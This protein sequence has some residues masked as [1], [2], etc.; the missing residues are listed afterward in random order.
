MKR[1]V[2]RKFWL[3]AVLMV[4]LAGCTERGNEVQNASLRM[5]VDSLWSNPQTAL[6]SL[7]QIEP[8]SLT[9]TERH[10]FI[11]T[12]AH[13]RLKL[14][15]VLEDE[16]AVNRAAAYCEEEQ[17]GRYAGEAYY[18]EGAYRN[19]TG[20]DAEAMQQ[21]K[22][23]ERAFDDEDVPAILLGM[24]YYKMGRI[25]ETEQLYAVAE[26]YYEQAVPYLDSAALPLYAACGWR[27]L[28][29]TTQDSVIRK[30]AFE[31][32]GFT[33]QPHLDF[34]I[35]CTDEEA[36]WARLS[37]NRKRQI[38]RA[39]QHGVHIEE[40]QNE[41]EIEA[42]YKILE[43]LYRTKVKTPLFPLSFFLTFY[44]QRLGKYLLVKHEGQIIGGIM[45]PVWNG[46][47]IYEWFVC[48]DD[49]MYKEQYPSVMSTYAAMEYAQ[50][51][52]LPRFD[53]MGAG[54]PDKA[55]SVRD[56][57][58]RFG[59]QEVEYGRWLYVN[60]PALYKLGELGVKVLRR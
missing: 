37:D 23:A 12:R 11:I 25:S 29:R 7:E 38:K 26:R 27:E 53:L 54:K 46:K 36:M 41:Q 30:E 6:V 4:A 35:D 22:R 55:Y 40:A 2:M 39:M 45:C 5:A 13:A 3:L 9:E 17:L 50:K 32:A 43:T 15:R 8:D 58:A 60:K 59:G 31:K 56:F 28:G 47:C 34:H 42:W 1:R 51:N 20:R 52:G 33:Y 24:T 14:E 19:L 57:K 48:G 49:K 18:I 21:L 10:I 44:R 16:E